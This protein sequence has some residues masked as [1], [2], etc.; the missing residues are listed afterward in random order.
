MFAAAPLPEVNEIRERLEVIFPD[1][2]PD[3]NYLIREVAAKT[4]FTMLYIDA[5][6]GQDQ[7]LAPK[8]VYRISDAIAED[9]TEDAR[10]A[11]V[12]NVRKPRYQPPG[13]PWYSDNSR[14][15]IRDESLRDGL[16]M[17]GAVTV[18]E[19]VPTT[20]GKGRYALKRH[21]AEL[22]LLPREEFED[23]IEKWRESNLSASALA[24][25]RI[26]QQR[27]TRDGQVP[28]EL[29]NG[30]R[31]VMEAGPSSEITRGVV[32]DFA[33]RFL[34]APAVLWISASGRK[35]IEHDDRLMADLGLPIDQQKLLPDLVMA[36]LGSQSTKLF[37]VEIV[38]TDGPITE[39]RRRSFLKLAAEGGYEAGDIVFVSA[40]TDRNSP[41]LK[42]RFSAIA[43]DTIIWCMA[44]PDLLIWMEEAG[45]LPVSRVDWQEKES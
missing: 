13:T 21:F 39:S 4:V 10:E 9:Q 43:V 22:F 33:P 37:F 17:I 1:G 38:A 44:E 36:D 35:V 34:Q 25:V 41:A 7:W 31:R 2:T 30:E 5:V 42:K 19:D 20:S 32:E 27:H 15:Q 11:Y 40:F 14:E 18:K 24:R 28:V 45:E 26:M 8:H 16:V 6:E 23:H 12:Q 3:R 29:P